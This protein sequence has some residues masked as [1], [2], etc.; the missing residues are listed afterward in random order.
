MKAGASSMWASCCGLLNEVMGTGAVRG[1]QPGFGAGA[2][3]FRF[4]PT[5]GYSTYTPT[6]ST[7][8]SLVCQACG[9]AFSVFRRRH[10]CCDCKK[11][12]CLLCSVLQENLRRCTTCQLLKGTAFQRP[13]LMRLRVK[14]LRQYLTL[15]NINTDTCREKEDLV[16]LVLCH[17][18]TESEDDPD[19]PSLHSRPLYSPPPSIEEPA[20]PL[21]ALSPTQGEPISRSNSSESTNQDIEDSTSVSLL[22][23]DQTE[24]TPEVSPQ[25]WRRARASLSDLSS[26]DDVE[27]LSVRQLKEILARNFVS[28]SGCCEKWE[29]VERVRR[30]YRENED[31]R[32]SMEN[33]SNPITAVVAYPPPICNGGIGDGCK[34]QLSNDDNLCR[35]CMDA[36]IDCVLLECGHMVTCTKCGKRMSECPICRQYVIRAVHVFKS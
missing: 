31:N 25:T 6:N 20:S 16:D 36:I 8:T 18:G 5:A 9:Q 11:S 33:V 14:D 26:L 21:S 29:L 22:N 1:Q 19:T 3:P 7:S 30:L 28:F 35:I 2:G 17:Q 24:H 34:T 23:L 10:I 32:K 15:R 13:Q 4:A 27:Q 12:F